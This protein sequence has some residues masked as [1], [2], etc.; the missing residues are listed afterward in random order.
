MRDRGF[1]S[2]RQLDPRCRRVCVDARRQACHR[3]HRTGFFFE[4]HMALALV[5][6]FDLGTAPRI[7]KGF[8]LGALEQQRR[9]AG[10]CEERGE[11][12]EL[13]RRACARHAHAVPLERFD[14][15]GHR[16]RAVAQTQPM[17]QRQQARE[18][19]AKCRHRHKREEILVQR[20]LG[21]RESGAR[22]DA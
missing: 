9:Q 8:A 19:R 14:Q 1:A 18:S 3:F 7:C 12:V 17:T 5:E 4:Q 2:E 6:P 22:H 15:L 13:L 10:R 21:L 16:V 11:A 20:F